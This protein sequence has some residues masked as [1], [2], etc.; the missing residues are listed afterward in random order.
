L[1][2]TGDP[3]HRD[4]GQHR[5]EEQVQHRTVDAEDPEA[6]PVDELELVLDLE[7]VVLLLAEAIDHQ[8]QDEDAEVDPEAGQHDLPGLAHRDLGRFMNDRISCIVNAN[9]ITNSAVNA[10]SRPAP[11]RTR[12]TAIASRNN[13]PS[14]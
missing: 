5:R 14:R 2:T 10:A 9:T 7:L 12:I 8:Q 1:H 4:H 3:H 13:R 11:L 6:H